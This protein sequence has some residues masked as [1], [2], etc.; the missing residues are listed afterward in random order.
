VSR[1]WIGVQIQPV[2]ADIADSLGLKGA[3]GALVAEPQANGR[4]SRPASRR[5]VIIAVNA[6]RFAMRVISHAQDWCDVARYDRAPDRAAE[7]SGEAISVTLGELPNRAVRL[8]PHPRAASRRAVLR[9]AAWLD[10]GLRHRGR[11]QR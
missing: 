8:A 3:Q 5:D 1:G 4:R 11:R 10:A 9:A 2:T 6:R 7:W